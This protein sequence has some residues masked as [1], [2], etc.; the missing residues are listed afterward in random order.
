MK[1]IALGLVIVAAIIAS[2]TV[3]LAVAM[4][5]RFHDTSVLSF[6]ISGGYALEVIGSYSFTVPPPPFVE[7]RDDLIVR[8]WCNLD[9]Y[10]INVRAS[11]EISGPSNQITLN[12]LH[13][14]GLTETLPHTP[15]EKALTLS[16]SL[17]FTGVRTIQT[18]HTAELRLTNLTAL[19]PSG[20]YSTTVVFTMVAP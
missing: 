18:D 1:R 9:T 14:I 16:D 2:A 11:A 20:T 15:V 13:Y 19:E 7:Q 8:T 10:R 4:G 6:T 5:D 12:N 3:G 17:W